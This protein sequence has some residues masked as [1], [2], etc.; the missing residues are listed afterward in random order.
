M[1]SALLKQRSQLWVGYCVEKWT[2]WD[3]LLRKL[4]PPHPD[5]CFPNGPLSEIAHQGEHY[6]ANAEGH[7]PGILVTIPNLLFMCGFGCSSEEHWSIHTSSVK[8][9]PLAR[10]FF[11]WQ[12]WHCESFQSRSV[13]L[14]I[15]KEEKKKR[16]KI[17]SSP[18]PSATSP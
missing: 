13:R 18:W 1:L 9:Q 14:M 7:I 3:H 12:C 2:C 11:T 16:R 15:S 10:P 5:K 17:A 8:R 4:S 6:T